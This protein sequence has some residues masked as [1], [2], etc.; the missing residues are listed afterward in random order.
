MTGQQHAWVALVAGSGKQGQVSVLLSL[1]RFHDPF[2]L[3][4]LASS[5]GR[6]LR[7]DNYLNWLLGFCPILGG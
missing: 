4:I 6:N 3:D 5:S 1:E 2:R 7:E